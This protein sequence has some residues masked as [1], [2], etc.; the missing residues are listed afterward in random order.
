MVEK[1]FLA[2]VV[3]TPSESKRLIGKAVANL[4]E[5]QKA[6]KKGRIIIVAS[7][8]NAFVV[9]ELLGEKIEKQKFAAGWINEGLLGIN[10]KENRM[11]PYIF[12]NG[13][14]QDVT[15]KEILE[16]FQGTDV[17]IKG[18][19]AVDS[20]GNAGIL[21][22]SKTGGSVAEIIGTAFSIGAHFI[23][24]V[25]LEKLVPSVP[26]AAESFKY[27]R[28]QIYS[29]Q[30]NVGF[31]PVIGAKVITEIEAF[32]SLTNVIAVHVAAGGIGGSEGSVVLNLHGAQEE[33]ENAIKLI[34]S[35]KGELPI[36]PV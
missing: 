23:I 12:R 31:M 9:E 25:G 11:P 24:P 34:E 2:T 5:V 26:E 14:V 28:D 3:L 30:Y 29:P 19:N 33:V 18:A 20:Y 10:K 22:A 6:F 8:T 13:E 1:Y 36:K 21:L 32:E 16:E 35:V 15:P 17:C 4:P 27:R 7:T